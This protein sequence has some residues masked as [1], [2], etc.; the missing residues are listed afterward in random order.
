LTQPLQAFLSRFPADEGARPASTS[1]ELLEQFR[2]V[3]PDSL[4]ALW[5]ETGLGWYGEGLLQLVSP[6]DYLDT[7]AG[8]LARDLSDLTRVPVALTAFGKLVYYRRLG[9]DAEDV[10]VLDPHRPG[11]GAEVLAWSLQDSFNEALCDP[12]VQENMLDREVARQAAARLGKLKPGEMFF[13]RPALMLGG[14]DDLDSVGKGDAAV[15]LDFLLQ[16]AL[17]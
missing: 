10:S 9:E 7:L 11:G 8:W 13:Y 6:L 12:E 14:S 15:Q 4:L 16:L 1:T 2:G 5:V 3:L 17:G